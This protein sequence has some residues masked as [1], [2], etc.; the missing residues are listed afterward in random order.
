MRKAVVVPMRRDFVVGVK[1][2]RCKAT[3]CHIETV[4]R[5]PTREALLVARE[6]LAATRHWKRCGGR[7]RCF[8]EELAGRT[9]GLG[10]RPQ[11]LA[12]PKSMMPKKSGDA[13]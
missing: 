2:C 12:T 10:R 4:R 3:R 11:R 9:M 5:S 7:I 1:C 8:R 6:K 13:A